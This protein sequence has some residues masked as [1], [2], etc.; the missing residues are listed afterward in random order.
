MRARSSGR[1]GEYLNILLNTLAKTAV[2]SDFTSVM[3]A[4]LKRVWN[5]SA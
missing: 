5:F 3:A 4:A 2:H 1:G